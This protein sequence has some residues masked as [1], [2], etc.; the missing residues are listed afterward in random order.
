MFATDEG[1]G[2]EVDY[3]ALF[4]ARLEKEGGSAVVGAKAKAK[5]VARDAKSSLSDAMPDLGGVSLP[6][7][8]MRPQI[9]DAQAKAKGLQ[10]QNQWDFTLISLGMVVVLAI[11][12]PF[13]TGS[14]APMAASNVE[15][16]VFGTRGAAVPT[17]EIGRQ[18]NAINQAMDE[19]NN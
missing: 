9:N 8:N 5:S 11:L 17:T 7:V 14:N 13:A 2:E 4:E 10:T 18:I 12:L 1:G 19:D 16:G 3:N 15:P 6:N